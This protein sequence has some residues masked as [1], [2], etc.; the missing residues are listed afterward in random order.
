MLV[1][2]LGPRGEKLWV[3]NSDFEAMTNFVKA[4]WKEATKMLFQELKRRSPHLDIM[5]AMG[6][7]FP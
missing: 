6:V 3:A 2:S 5:E 4:Q 1:H 7:V